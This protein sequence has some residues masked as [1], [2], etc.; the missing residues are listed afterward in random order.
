[1][2]PQRWEVE[3]CWGWKDAAARWDALNAGGAAEMRAP[4]LLFGERRCGTQHCAI[5]I[6]RDGLDVGS[7]V[8]FLAERNAQRSGY[9]IHDLN[10]PN[11]AGLDAA[12]GPTLASVIPGTNAA[13]FA[14]AGGIDAEQRSHISSLL[15]EEA[16]SL[17]DALCA[18]SILFP[19]VIVEDCPEYNDIMEA[20]R[21]RNFC[22][23]E[24]QPTFVI[25]LPNSF[26]EF[27]LSLSHNRRSSLR[28]ELREFSRRGYTVERRTERI[29]TLPGVVSL[30]HDRF[31]KHGH[32][33]SLSATAERLQWFEA[34]PGFVALLARDRD[35]TII[36]FDANVHDEARGR[37][38]GKYG[39]TLVGSNPAYFVL[40]FTE[41]TRLA[42]DLGCHRV[43]LG[44]E[45][46]QAKTLRGGRPQRRIALGRTCAP[47]GPRDRP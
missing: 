11:S 2:R 36:G 26:D 28:R 6:R 30:L 45:A 33:T 8:F 23:W 47:S 32:D 35:G 9:H 18:D 25:P 5:F 22:V 44:V 4:W 34:L 29:S 39:G 3:V 40:A 38:I 46:A 1:M 37:L 19:S 14:V 12:M 43:E 20:A 13:G 27:V 42:I 24:L 15:V 21:G 31:T 10:A 16:I 41:A 17:A 7:A